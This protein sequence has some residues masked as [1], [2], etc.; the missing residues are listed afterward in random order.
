MIEMKRTFCI[1]AISTG[2]A[3]LAMALS[4]QPGLLL[5]EPLPGFFGEG[6]IDASLQQKISLGSDKIPFI[7]IFNPSQLP[8]REKLEDASIHIVRRFDIIPGAAGVGSAR[9]IRK[10]AHEQWIDGLYPDGSVHVCGPVRSEDDFV[11][12]SPA[13]KVNASYLW[14]QGINGS[15]VTVAVLDS[16]INQN[17]PD[18]IGKV[19]GEVNFVKDEETTNDLLGHGTMVAGIIAGSGEASGGRYMGIAPGARLLNVRVIDSDGNGQDS[20]IIAGIE[21]ALNNG[22]DVISM[23]LGGLD[24]GETDLPV[25]TAADNAMDAGA[26]V[27]VAAGNSG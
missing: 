1:L 4:A 25:T 12:E 24:L 22:A 9:A 23:S 16:G 17:H 18:L 10:L 19:V 21:W 8:N 5:S 14:S 6:K 2:L 13:K 27:C 7:M 20:D 26:I 3:I 15:G 11:G